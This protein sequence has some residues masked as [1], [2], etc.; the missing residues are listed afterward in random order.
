MESEKEKL[1]REISEAKKR[2]KHLEKLEKEASRNNTI[3]SLD[4]YTFQE[5]IDFF[6]KIY[7]NSLQELVD[8][9]KGNRHDDDSEHYAWESCIEIL[10]R[11]SKTFWDYWNSLD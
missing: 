5:K 2:I 6:D 10:A 1:K 11:D 9:E 4:E 3:K 7:N 8:Y